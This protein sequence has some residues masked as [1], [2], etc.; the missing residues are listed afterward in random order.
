LAAPE[1]ERKQKDEQKKPSSLAGFRN[2]AIAAAIALGLRFFAMEPFQIPTGSMEPTLIGREGWGDRIFAGKFSY[3]R[4]F[5]SDPKR[6]DVVV[7]YLSEPGM[8]TKRLVK[9]LVGLPQETV[10]IS[11]GDI[12]VNG[13][14]ERKPEAIEKV[15]W[16]TLYDGTYSDP[17]EARHWPWVIETGATDA[18]RIEGGK[19][20]A[21][22]GKQ[23]SR[24]STIRYD[25]S[26]RGVGLTNIYIRRSYRAFACPYCGKEVYYAVDTAHTWVPCPVCSKEKGRPVDFNV[27]LN[28]MLGSS[29][30]F[31]R[32]PVTVHDEVEMNDLAVEAQWAGDGDLGG[33]VTLTLLTRERRF[34]VRYVPGIS[35][36]VVTGPIGGVGEETLKVTPEGGRYVMKMAFWDDT[37]AV[38]WKGQNIWIKEIEPKRTLMEMPKPA[39][40]VL[41]TAGRGKTSFDRITIQRDIYYTT[42]GGNQFAAMSKGAYGLFCNIQDGQYFFLGDNSP[43]SRDSRF[44]GAINRP[45]LVGRAWF[46]FWPLNRVRWVR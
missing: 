20:V 38:Y 36:V 26:Q 16:H 27:V 3:S 43:S 15:L 32:Y 13:K 35:S 31:D 6:W 30:P 45:A 39:S 10:E 9:R 34:S 29:T 2:L 18:W 42:D 14:L 12:F 23:G 44:W 40:S 11:D 22:N 8:E 17:V 1:K 19:L 41:V 7:F 33:D 37:L 5:G 24:P 21:D 4:T 28:N 46:V 25:G